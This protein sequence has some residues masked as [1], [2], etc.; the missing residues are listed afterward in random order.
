MSIR[1]SILGAVFCGWAALA[2]AGLGEWTNVGI[3]GAQV[4][5]VEYVRDGVAIAVTAGG[6]YRTTNHG[7]SWNRVRSMAPVNNFSIAVNSANP[8]QILVTGEGA[9]RSGDR[10][11]TFTRI[12]VDVPLAAMPAVVSVAFSHDGFY[13]WLIE[14]DGD[15]RRSTDGGVTWQT[16]PAVLP[17][18]EYWFAD[19]DVA[20]RNTVYAGR[21]LGIHASR[22]GGATWTQLP[23]NGNFHPQASRTTTGRLIAIQTNSN[24][25][26]AW[27]NDIGQTWNPSITQPS[28]FGLKTASDSRAF[29]IDYE[30]GFHSSTDDGSTW[31]RRGRLPNGFGRGVSVDPANPQRLL[32]GTLAGIVRSEDGGNTWA[33]SNAGL[34]EANGV[35]IATAANGGTAVYVATS[36]LGSVYRRDGAGAYSA[37]A[38]SSSPALGYPGLWGY[39]IVVAPQ[40]PNTLYM[41]R[42]ERLGRSINGGNDWTLLATLPFIYSLTLDPGNPLV[43]YAT[44]QDRRLKSVDGG[45]TWSPFGVTLP[46]NVSSSLGRVYVDPE[47]SAHLFALVHGYSGA[48]SPVYHSMDAGVTWTPSNW[49]V[50][51]GPSPF[52]PNAMAFEPGRSSTI[53][54]VME[55]G[56]YKSVDSGL[57][58]TP[59]PRVGGGRSVV[60]DPQSP[61][62]V[63]TAQ[64]S[65]ELQRS[66]DGGATWTDALD[67]A[68]SAASFPGFDRVA[69]VPGHNAKLLGIRND[70]G[71]YE[72]DVAPRLRLGLAPATITAGTPGSFVLNVLNADVMTAT[73][74]RV[75][76]TLPPSAGSYGL[77]ANL[78]SCS[79]NVRELS[80]DIG[81]LAPAATAS[82]TVTFTPSGPGATTFNLSAYEPLASGSVSSVSLNVD[83]ASPVSPGGGGGGGGGRLDYLLLALL[84]GIVGFRTRLSPS[85]RARS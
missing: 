56:T 30:A 80:C 64:G 79:V 68:A 33:E 47:N 73:R 21:G 24:A 69:L 27:S 2:N 75:T 20:D 49:T 29:A 61:Q 19:T 76:A 7:G 14:S 81:T 74:V 70:G 39:Q 35:G 45:V 60:V 78:G 31:T 34:L 82:M 38:R 15:V 46:A 17:P 25:G 36:D 63:Y 72:I 42:G 84:A 11:L 37:V 50:T 58:W 67:L 52:S 57:N 65:R 54:L 6:I 1:Q 44:G 9:Y 48:L 77:V 23:A 26:V 71:V 28:F 32:V 13:A 4:L 51:T 10:G 16:F 18:G 12:N 66:V 40:N 41:M 83:A 55:F 53:Y 85:A 59:M 43:M 22:D 3:P 8:D 5:N 62:I